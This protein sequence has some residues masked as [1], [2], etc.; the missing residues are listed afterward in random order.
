MLLVSFTTRTA[1]VSCNF[2]RGGAIGSSM[3]RLDRKQDS[4]ST[5]VI[6]L[7]QYNECRPDTSMLE[8]F[9]KVAGMDNFIGGKVGIYMEH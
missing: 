8:Q 7:P 1:M 2:V 3:R 9:C 5:C 4:T 6:T